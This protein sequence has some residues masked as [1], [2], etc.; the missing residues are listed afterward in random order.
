MRF[1]TAGKDTFSCARWGSIRLCFGSGNG[2]GVVMDVPAFVDC[3]GFRH[4]CAVAADVDRDMVFL[5]V[6]ADVVEQAL[7]AGDADDSVASEAV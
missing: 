2:L 3:Q 1:T 4:R 7:E 5:A 6:A